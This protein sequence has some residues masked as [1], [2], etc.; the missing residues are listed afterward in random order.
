MV[1]E[2][3]ILWEADFPKSQAFTVLLHLCAGHFGIKD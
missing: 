2:T 1:L 3:P